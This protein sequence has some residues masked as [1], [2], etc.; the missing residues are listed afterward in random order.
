MPEHQ[1]KPPP[2]AWS[3][4][5]SDAMD[6]LR[7]LPSEQ[8]DTVCTDPPYGISYKNGSLKAGDPDSARHAA[9]ANDDAPFVW[10]L[11]EAWRVTRPGGCLICFAGWQTSDTFREAIRWAGWRLRSMVVWDKER[12]GLGD[13]RQ[14]FAPQHEIIWFAVKA[15]ASG[16]SAGFR[17][18]VCPESGR[19]DRPRSV[20]RC[21]TPPLSMRTHPT[22]KPV[23][24]LAT[25]IRATTPAGGLVIDPFSGTGSTG[26]AALLEG[27]RFAGCE[28]S[29]EYAATARQRLARSAQS[30]PPPHQ[31]PLK[32]G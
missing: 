13:F 12:P 2:P 22:E 3:L 4:D 11:R 20:L 8:A 6:W 23:E 21:K 16:R 5:Q 14:D 17:F 32:A 7:Q 18:Q 19:L 15:S 9:I 31:R 10:W 24:L 29:A 25:L 26:E 27:R 30:A 1:R 28:L